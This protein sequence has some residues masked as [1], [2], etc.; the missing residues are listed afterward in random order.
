[1]SGLGALRA[2]IDALGGN[3]RADGPPAAPDLSAEVQL[4]VGLL[5]AADRL[6]GTSDIE[7]ITALQAIAAA[8]RYFQLCA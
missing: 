4:L 8:R 7:D 5:I 3:F 2:L 1:L 6:T